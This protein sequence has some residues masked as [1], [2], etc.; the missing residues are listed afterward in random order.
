MPYQFKYSTDLSDEPF[1]CNIE[2]RQCEHEILKTNGTHVRCKMKVC[3]GLPYCWRHMRSVLHLRVAKSQIPEAGNGVYA[4]HPDPKV[5]RVFRK[6]QPITTYDGELL[7]QEEV[8]RRYT[9]SEEV[10]SPYTYAIGTTE[11]YIDAACTR[12]VGGMFNFKPYTGKRNPNNVYAKKVQNQNKVMLYANR[13]IL[14]G[15]EMFLDYG[16]AYKVELNKDLHEYHTTNYV[17]PRRLS[18]RR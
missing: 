10:T 3:I 12:G 17:R 6:N 5:R 8:D 14:N 2:C 16:R 13:D 1:V 15:E 7:N 11:N 9:N 4:Y 18:R